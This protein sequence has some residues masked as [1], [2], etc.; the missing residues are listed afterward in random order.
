M[1]W[2]ESSPCISRVHCTACPYVLG[3]DDDLAQ[4][5]LCFRAAEARLIGS[6]FVP[7]AGGQCPHGVTLKVAIIQREVR[8]QSDARNG[9]KRVLARLFNLAAQAGDMAALASVLSD[10]A[11]HRDAQT[12][13]LSEL[14]K[15]AEGLG[16]V[17]ANA[18]RAVLR[19]CIEQVMATAGNEQAYWEL[20]RCVIAQQITAA[21]ATAAANNIGIVEPDYV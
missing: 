12:W 19:T 2:T 5:T 8:R 21:E 20:R 17:P 14:V 6:H 1:K 9:V 7:E 3:W 16:Y 11:Q 18:H 4:A 15:D 13:L 10:I